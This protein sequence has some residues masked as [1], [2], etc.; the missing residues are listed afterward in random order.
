LVDA[1]LA[2]FAGPAEKLGHVWRVGR[3]C[4]VA[5]TRLPVDCL[6]RF[7]AL[8]TTVRAQVTDLAGRL[9]RLA[10][11]GDRRAALQLAAGGDRATETV[12]RRK[13]SATEVL[14]DSLD[15]LIEVLRFRH[16][17]LEE[18]Q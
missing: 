6:D 4:R 13:F 5:A 18:L 2:A 10:A 16:D 9:D 8:A 15:Q 14:A 12:L 3:L 17:L 11:A 7:A 1:F